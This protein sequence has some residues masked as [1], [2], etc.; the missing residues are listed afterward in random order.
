[1][2]NVVDTYVKSIYYRSMDRIPHI[3]PTFDSKL[4]KAV[5]ELEKLRYSEVSGSTPPWLFFDLKEIMHFL[6]SIASARIEGNRTTLVSAADDVVN[7]GNGSD[8]E[9]L[10]ELRN[11]REGIDFIEKSVTAEAKIDL[12]MIR[13]LH[14]ITVQNLTEDG[15]KT[16]GKFRTE[17]VKIQ[18]STHKPPSHSVVKSLMSDLS[19]YINDDLGNQYDIIK[20]AIAHHRFTAIHPFDNGNGR[21]ARL[22][23][24]AMLVR[25]G[26]IDNSIRLLN[27][28]SIFCMDR[29][30]YYKKLEKAD[31]GTKKELESWSLYVADGILDEVTRVSKLLNKK[32]TVENI[33]LP[34]IKD[35]RNN[36]HISDVEFEILTIAMDKNLIQAADVRH[37]FG[38]T[39]SA[40]VQ[41]SRILATMKEKGLIMSHPKSPNKYVIRFANNHLLGGVLK[42]MAANGLLPATPDAI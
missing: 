3:N 22:I 33:L 37:L 32:Y 13:E 40:R 5:F 23:T 20:I 21:T 14:K 39:A 6:E 19:D 34:V 36:K 38:T 1:M 30:E 41:T 31:I 10:L 27:P 12:N 26:F 28:S 4:A 16:P 9:S 18:K 11:I 2:L 8:D 17:D 15:S 24:Y 35:A 29:N 25:S 7:S 42:E